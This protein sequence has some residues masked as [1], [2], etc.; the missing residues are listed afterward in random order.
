MT[1]RWSVLLVEDDT[2][3]HRLAVEFIA[4]PSEA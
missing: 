1:M 3:V 4:A 2:L